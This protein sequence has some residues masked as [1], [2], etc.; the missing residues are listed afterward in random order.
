MYIIVCLVT[1]IGRSAKLAVLGAKTRYSRQWGL[2][3][4]SL[5]EGVNGEL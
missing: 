4:E 2:A 3:G 5:N 1:G